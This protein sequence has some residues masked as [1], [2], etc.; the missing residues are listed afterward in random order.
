MAE[1]DREVDETARI[2]LIHQIGQSL[3][4]D[5]VLLPLYQF[6]NIAAWRTDKL[7]GPVDEF[8]GNYMSAFK[9]L[10]KWEPAG[11]SEI[12]IGAEQWPDCLNPVTECAN[13]SWMVWTAMFPM[14]PGVWDT[15]EDGYAPTAVVTEEPTVEVA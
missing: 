5:S 10:N 8:A 2:D 3:V 4:D 1:S 13:S 14:L 7:G 15:T 11:G 12:I 6:P 9:N